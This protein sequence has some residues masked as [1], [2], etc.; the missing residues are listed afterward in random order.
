MTGVWSPEEQ[1]KVTGVWSPEEQFK[2]TGVWSPEE[3]FKVT[4]VWSPDDR[5]LEPGGKMCGLH[6]GRNVLHSTESEK[7]QEI[8]V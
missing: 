8:N 1:F 6:K 4:G 3:Q 2:V 5:C 7:S